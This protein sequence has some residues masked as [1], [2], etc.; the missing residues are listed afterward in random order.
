MFR[1]LEDE[2]SSLLRDPDWRGLDV[3]AKVNL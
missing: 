2:W 1:A 3:W